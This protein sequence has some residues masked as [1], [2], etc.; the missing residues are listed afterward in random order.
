MNRLTSGAA[1]EPSAIEQS[2]PAGRFADDL[3]SCKPPVYDAPLRATR[4]MRVLGYH[5]HPATCLHYK[6][7][8]YAGSTRWHCA[9]C[10]ER[11]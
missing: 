9:D 11:A 10:G 3:P 7:R 1:I 6:K 2:T 5:A 8:L 4:I